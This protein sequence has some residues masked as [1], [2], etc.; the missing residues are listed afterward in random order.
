[1][2]LRIEVLFCVL[3]SCSL[4]TTEAVLVIVTDCG[5]ITPCSGIEG[6]RTIATVVEVLGAKFPK[7]QVIG[8]VPVQLPPGAAVVAE[9]TR[10]KDLLGI[11][12][13]SVSTIPVASSGPLLATV[14]V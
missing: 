10:V 3:L 12:K 9:I 13:S 4:L 2:P 7:V 8:P 14:M 1:M 5:G 11:V 6:A